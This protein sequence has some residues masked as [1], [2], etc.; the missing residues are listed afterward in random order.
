M[1][2]AQT[3]I[4][5]QQTVFSLRTFK[6]HFKIQVPNNAM[7]RHKCLIQCV[8]KVLFKYLTCFKQLFSLGF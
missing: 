4:E 3:N 8:F 1:I 2:V 7:I 5:V 6:V